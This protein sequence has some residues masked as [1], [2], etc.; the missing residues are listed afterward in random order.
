MG[1]IAGTCQVFRILGIATAPRVASRV[2]A[3]KS[4]RNS[5]MSSST[6]TKWIRT[7]HAPTAY[8]II[9]Y[10]L[11]TKYRVNRRNNHTLNPLSLEPYLRSITLNPNPVTPQVFGSRGNR[12]PRNLNLIPQTLTHKAQN[13]NP[14][15]KPLF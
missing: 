3:W 14:N 9:A 6:T 8:G 1:I 7:T 12:R 5:G 2:G 10:D 4:L 11:L 15:P 13:L